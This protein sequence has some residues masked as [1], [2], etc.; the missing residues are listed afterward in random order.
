[1]RF[2]LAMLVTIG[3]LS[4]AGCSKFRTYNGP[5][6]TRIVVM[7]SERKLYLFNDETLLKSFDVDLGFAPEGP[8]TERG[9]GRTPEG[10][11]YIDRKNPD[12]L[13]HLSVGLSYP[14]EDDR[15]AA[16]EAGVS[17]GGDI[18]IHGAR[19]RIDRRGPDWT[20]GCIAVSNREIEEIYSMVNVGT[21]IDLFP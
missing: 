20:A 19:R 12:S 11:Y 16:K 10:R 6:V 3:L 18:F 17:P 9:D 8:K 1:M 5:E 4:Q 2:L 13:F 15:A 14:N 21:T 7:K